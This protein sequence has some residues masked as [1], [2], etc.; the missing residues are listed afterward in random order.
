MAG[1]SGLFGRLVCRSVAC[2]FIRLVVGFAVSFV[3]RLVGWAFGRSVCWLVDQSVGCLAFLSV[4]LLVGRC[5]DRLFCWLL[6]EQITFSP[7][8]PVPIKGYFW[9]FV[10][11][12]ILASA[13]NGASLGGIGRLRRA[14]CLK[15]TIF[16]SVSMLALDFP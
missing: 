16:S 4:G 13:T 10:S 8:S 9:N 15:N 6:R 2:S 5:V 7:A 14:R 3:G 1:F 11:R 12:T